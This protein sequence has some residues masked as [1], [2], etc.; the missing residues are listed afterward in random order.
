MTESEKIY[1]DI[2]NHPYTAPARHPRM[3][4]EDRAAQFSPFAALV[5]YEAS[6]LEEERITEERRELSDEERMLINE[7]LMLILESGAECEVNVRFFIPDEKKSGGRYECVN[8]VLREVDTVD[9]V[10]I[11]ADGHRISL[12]DVYAVDREIFNSRELY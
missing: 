5:G 7:R 9:G 3:R 2:I 4:R 8:D 11:M 6:I 12:A 10:L 1:G